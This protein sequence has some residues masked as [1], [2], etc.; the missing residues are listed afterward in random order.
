M[1][2][3]TRRARFVATIVILTSTVGGCA[4]APLEGRTEPVL[5]RQSLAEIKKVV[6][7]IEVEVASFAPDE[8]TVAMEEKPG[9]SISDCAPGGVSWGSSTSVVMTEPADLEELATAL[10]AEWPRSRHFEIE[11][12]E[13]STGAPRLALKSSEFG[14]YYVRLLDD[15]LQVLSFST[16]FAY[17][18]ERDGYAWEIAAE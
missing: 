7:D 18:E 6:K 17:D 8:L 3:F 1:T 15:G 10:R 5:S 2:Q 13:G 14:N 16:C 12:T 4:M 11:L 9:G